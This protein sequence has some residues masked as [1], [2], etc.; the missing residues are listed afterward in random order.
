MEEIPGVIS[1]WE[2]NFIEVSAAAQTVVDIA[3]A[4][5][6]FMALGEYIVSGVAQLV[7]RV[8]VNH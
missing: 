2:G 3:L 6:I 7:E 8:A 5:L 4:W 1:E